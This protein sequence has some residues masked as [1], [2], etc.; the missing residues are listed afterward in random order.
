MS[1]GSPDL[2]IGITFAILNFTGT[3]PCSIDLLNIWSKGDEIGASTVLTRC[4]EILFRSMLFLLWS[5][6]IA[7]VN[8]TCEIGTLDMKNSLSLT[9]AWLLTGHG[10]IFDEIS[11]AMDVK[12]VL[13]LFA[14]SVGLSINV[15]S[16]K[17]LEIGDLLL[18]TFKASLR[19]CHVFL[20][21]FLL[22]KSCSL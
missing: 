15:L 20:R 14:I 4:I 5:S 7:L 1:N 17:S 3:T 11:L 2:K 13:N 22:I 19:I 9:G 8:S 21:L 6:L 18:E 16:T 12:K 10:L